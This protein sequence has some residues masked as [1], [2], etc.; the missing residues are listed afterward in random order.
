MG[1][2]VFPKRTQQR[3]FDALDAF[4][5]ELRDRLARSMILHDAG[6]T[7]QDLLL[8]LGWDAHRTLLTR[9]GITPDIAFFSCLDE[10]H[11]EAL[12]ETGYEAS[13]RPMTW[14]AIYQAAFVGSPAEA[15]PFRASPRS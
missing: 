4:D 10:D 9:V 1:L 11:L 8:G 5:S 14:E 13:A 6:E 3:S 2:L 12:I 7:S 15:L